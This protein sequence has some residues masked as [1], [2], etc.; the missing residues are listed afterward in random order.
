ML[1]QTWPDSIRPRSRASA[2]GIHNLGQEVASLG[3]RNS[4]LQLVCAS[5][6]NKNPH[7]AQKVSHGP[8]QSAHLLQSA[9]RT[10]CS[11]A[12]HAL[13]RHASLDALLRVLFAYLTR[14]H[15]AAPL[16]HAQSEVKPPVHLDAWFA[17]CGLCDMPSHECGPTCIP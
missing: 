4:E 7:L 6:L 13:S 1:V 5:I 11:I 9:P 14:Q 15:N 17:H 10:L 2:S 8:A 3:K 16:S 12:A